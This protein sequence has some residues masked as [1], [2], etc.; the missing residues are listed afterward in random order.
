MEG[1]GYLAVTIQPGDDTDQAAFEDWYAQ[2]HGPLRLRLPFITSGDRYKAA[3]AQTPYWSAVYDITDIA[4]L[5]KRTYTRL[6]EERSKREANV[7]S[8]FGE[9]DRRIYRLV[10]TRSK[11]GHSGVAPVQLTE[12]YRLA[13]EDEAVVDKWYEGEHSEY[14]STLPNWLRTRKF[15]LVAG[16]IKGMPYEGQN[17]YLFVY[18]LSSTAGIDDPEHIDT[19][20]SDNAK[21]ALAKVT[22]EPSRLWNH[23]LT[24]DALEE[25]P[26]SVLTTDGAELRF[27][28][29]G[30]PT[31]PVVVFVNSILT[32]FHIW[33][34]VAGALLQGINGQTYRVLR[35]NSRGYSQQWSGSRD[36]HFDILADD[37]EY[38]LSRLRIEKVHA[39]VG[40]SMG[41]VTAINFA[42]RHPTLLDKY[43]ACDCNIAAGAAN[44]KAW[45]ERV[46]LARSQGMAALAKVTAERWFTEPNHG[47]P[48]FKRVLSMIEAAS[49]DG[50]EQNAGALSNYDLKSKL[51]TIKAPGLLVA[52]E[53]DGKLPEVMQT[54]EI[55]KTTFKTIPNAG[56][57]PMLENNEALIAALADFL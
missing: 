30:N 57:L 17:D 24:F 48:N 4:W 3:D 2:E 33:E 16:G 7:M 20:S 41:G 46:E 47:S 55:P 45:S 34:D 1:P 25:P 6:R 29:E 26:S 8:T 50:F 15:K 28:L 40:V 14:I 32:D 10:S 51:S 54:F 22:A 44:N 21:A 38:L 35:Y 13:V 49:V 52:G 18:D 27:Q 12:S 53:R 9:L 37:L 31:D 56:H 11:P 39:V 42:I 36:T 43:V 5:E 19:R 23:Y